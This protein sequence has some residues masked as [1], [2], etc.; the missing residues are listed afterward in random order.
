MHA[1]PRLRPK[2]VR[3]IFSQ[4]AF[5]TV[6]QNAR[7]GI[8]LGQRAAHKAQLARAHPPGVGKQFTDHCA[9]ARGIHAFGDLQEVPAQR[10]FRAGEQLTHIHATLRTRPV[11]RPAPTLAEV[12]ND[13]AVVQ[14]GEQLKRQASS[15][16]AALVK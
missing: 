12:Q 7:I 2:R 15:F 1:Q 5:Q 9:V 4:E 14:F 10:T 16:K 3:F 8:N 6:E 13:N 11:Q